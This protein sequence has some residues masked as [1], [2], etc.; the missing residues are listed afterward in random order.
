MTRSSRPPASPGR[1]NLG[2]RATLGSA[3]S[4]ALIGELKGNG[5]VE[6]LNGSDDTSAGLRRPTG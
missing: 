3:G 6:W 5:C 2:L 1:E 4:P